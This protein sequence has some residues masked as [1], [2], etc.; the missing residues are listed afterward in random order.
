MTDQQLEDYFYSRDLGC[1]TPKQFQAIEKEYLNIVGYCKKVKL[2][3]ENL[4]INSGERALWE[5]VQ[6]ARD[7]GEFCSI[8]IELSEDSIV[9]QHY[10]KPFSYSSLL[11]LVKQD[12]SKDD[13]SN[14]LAGQYGTGFMTTHAFNRVV[15]VFGPYEVRKSKTEVDK[16]INMHMV[17]DRSKNGSL[18]A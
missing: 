18:E 4:D 10:G 13:S 15:D 6:N 7:M 2:G 5:L 17:L 11:A 14:D 12:S 8:R 3:I 1:L 16:Y 9:F